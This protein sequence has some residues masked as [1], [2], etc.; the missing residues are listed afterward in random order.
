M[1]KAKLV[2]RLGKEG[3]KKRK[4]RKKREKGREEGEY[5]VHQHRF[6]PILQRDGRRVASPASAPKLQQDVPVFEPSI[7][8]IPTV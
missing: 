2:E 1:G 8:D 4:K 7:L 6:D 5:I 3:E